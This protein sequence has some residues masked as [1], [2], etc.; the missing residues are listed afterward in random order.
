MVSIP[1]RQ[2]LNA[3]QEFEIWQYH[4]KKYD[5]EKHPNFLLIFKYV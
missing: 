3:I 5:F 4:F 2:K 1:V